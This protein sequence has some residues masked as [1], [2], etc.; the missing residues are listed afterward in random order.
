VFRVEYHP[1][2]AAELNR[3]RAF[4]R[5]RILDAIKR[6]LMVA[7]GITG[8]RRKR[9]DLGSGNVIH[10]LRVGDYRIFYDVDEAK[11]RVIVRHVRRKG[12]KTTGE[13]L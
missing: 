10:Q 13:I 8:G 3:L 11:L 6:H 2:A 5:G 12:Q 7:P 1:E 9:L 4:D